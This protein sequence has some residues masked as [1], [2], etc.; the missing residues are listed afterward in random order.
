MAGS[1]ALAYR[2]RLYTLNHRTAAAVRAF[3]FMILHGRPST[4]LQRNVA[5]KASLQRIAVGGVAWCLAAFV[6]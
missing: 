6:A 3:L 1:A 2:R 4:G 5:V